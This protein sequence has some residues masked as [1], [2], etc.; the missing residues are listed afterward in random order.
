M[1]NVLKEPLPEA[2][3]RKKLKR[4]SYKRMITLAKT[5]I[6]FT[7][8]STFVT[9]AKDRGD[10]ALVAVQHEGRIKHFAYDPVHRHLVE[11]A[12]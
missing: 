10:I 6:W 7:R 5:G 12:A 4:I 11:D 9:A 1:N 2:A 8:W 3:A